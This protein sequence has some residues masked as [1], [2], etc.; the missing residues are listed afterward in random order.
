MT[1]E[2]SPVGGGHQA[3]RQMHLAG[4]LKSL[5]PCDSRGS[6]A[7]R[8]AP[9]TARLVSTPL[10]PESLCS[11]TGTGAAVTNL[12]VD[13]QTNRSSSL[14]WEEPE[15]SDSQSLTYWVLP[16]A[17][18]ATTP[19]PVRNLRAVTQTNDSI[20]LGWEEPEGSDSQNLTYW[21]LWTGDGYGGDARNTTN[22]IVTVE[23]LRPGSSYAFSVWVEKD[24]VNSSRETLSAATAPNPVRN[25]R[26][27]TQTNDS[28]SLGWEEPEG[29]DSQNL[30]YWVLW[31]GDGHG[32]DTRN[33][34]DTSVA[35][36]GL[37]PGSSYVFSVW[38]EK[39]G[40]NSSRETL[41]AATAP[42]PVRNLRA[43]T[44]TNDSISLGWEEPEGSD[45]Q[46]LTYWV[47]WTGDGY[48]GDARNTTNTIVTVEG[49]RP[50][51]SYAFSVWVEKD[52]V[53][54]SRE[55]LS[56][57]TAPNPVRNL[58]AVTQTNDSISLGWE[59]PEGSDSQNLTYWV[60]WTGDGHG[61]DTRN[62]TDTSVAMEGLHPGSS[63]VFSVWVE[64]DGVNS[65]R[66]TLSAATAPNPVTN[67]RVDAQTN[68]SITLSWEEPEGSD[69]QNLTYWVLW[70][71]D[72]HGGDTWN[73]TDTSVTV[74]GLRPGSSYAFSV[75]VEKDG[76][77]STREFLSAAT[78]PNPVRNLRAVTQTNDSISLGW[79]EPEGS[80]SQNLTYWVLWTGDGYGGDARN[81]TNTSVTV[82]GL[83]PGSSYA[84]SVGVEKDGVNSTRETLSA[85]TAP[86]PVRNLRVVTQT[87]DSI[88]LGWEEPEGSD[89][90]NL[91]YWVLWTGDGLTSDSHN[92]EDTNVTLLV[93]YPGFLYEVLVWA[94]KNGINSSR[95]T[96]NAA[97]APNAVT[98]LQ[99]TNETST[100]VSLTWAAPVDTHSQRYTYWVQWA[101]E[102]QPP[103]VGVNL[104]CR[105][106]ETWYVVESLRPGTLY[107]FRV[108]AERHKVASSTKS[109]HA[110]TA[111]DSVTIAS[112][113]SASGGY[114]LYLNWSCPSGG[115][116]AFELEVGGQQ[117]TQDRS[118]CGSRVFVQ[119]LGPARSYTAT[120][121]TIWSGLKVQSASVTC[122]TES[123]GVIAGAVVGILLCLIL[124][125]LLVL[126]LKKRNSKKQKEEAMG[127]RLCTIPVEQ[128]TSFPGDITAKD[129]ADH[130]QR[131]EKDSNCGFADEYQHLCR[132]GE[133]QPQEAALAPENKAKNRY[134]NVLPYD[135]SRVPLQPLRD[136][137]GSDYINASFIPG[138]WSPRDF[139]AA[140]G[141]LLRTVG[142]FWRLVWE[143]QS[144]TIVMLTN[145]VESGRVKCEH[146]WPLD[147][148]P[149]THGHL[150]V[151]LVD[152][153]VTEDWAV[154]DLQLFHVEE[155]K[156]LPVRQFHYLAWPDHGVPPSPD[157]LL[158]FWRLL[159][160]W[161]DQTAE[162]GPPIVHC[163]A[164][165]GRTGTL[166]GLDVLLRQLEREGLVGPFSFVRKM[167]Q[168]RPLMVQTEVR[169]RAVAGSGLGAG[170]TP[171][172]LPRPST[173]SCTS[174]SCVTSSNCSQPPRPRRRRSTRTW[175][176]SSMRTLL[177]SGP[178]SWRSEPEAQ[179]RLLDPWDSRGLDLSPGPLELEPRAEW[180]WTL[181]LEGG[182]AEV[183]F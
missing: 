91:T 142:D 171:R 175:Q 177:P 83:R 42:N 119:G 179:P 67:L 14:G 110:S 69:S 111:P 76:V 44:Q 56:A 35:V 49:L 133:G 9:T 167:R 37:H 181:S 100:S 122:Y 24:G 43:V 77:S 41:S 20:S 46:N 10:S 105:T 58:R 4:R 39:D 38:V 130:V 60:L 109:L 170:L 116:E 19:N 88:S 68:S 26:A 62:S 164:G 104:T 64:K 126:F 136:E 87:N 85:A 166:I 150:Q 160:Q 172:L 90:Q 84:F 45:S 27:V 107:T 8:R 5:L 3:Q 112:C 157:P 154:R 125:G 82:E 178:R 18:H 16:A 65:S 132:E 137:P 120:V 149:C 127:Q 148:Q 182:E 57:A 70:T 22:T 34:T 180:A 30:T 25:L 108:C 93:L 63:Y 52:G 29:S 143:Q 139:I 33:S 53:N 118:S 128:T 152:E 50:G 75:W 47:L 23:G 173:C 74:E 12:R 89:S 28:I 124:V 80:D 117:V 21:V 121:T 73:I 159:R 161:L 169:L 138:L 1:S 71:G 114:G 162:G 7:D 163:S 147:A 54:S 59:E 11:W 95:E 153:E 61:G 55:T 183:G 151:A 113:V 141:P 13:A 94:E 92:T 72:G 101:S 51:S 81:T 123:A 115:Y 17:D 140:Q 86:N 96:Q 6:A 144:H 165:V 79:E 31:T 106:E 32:G 145:C 155:Q 146:Y 98:Q 176:A 48:G 168:S 156:A 102:A 174:A 103:E 99:N 158:A 134:R 40:V 2:P 15:G 135:W 36:E 129:F 78:A 131:N 66:E 97:T